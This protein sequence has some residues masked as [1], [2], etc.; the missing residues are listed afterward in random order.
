MVIDRE[1]DTVEH[2]I[3]R[4]IIDY[5]R[6]EDT[7]VINDTRVIPARIV[8]ERVVKMTADGPCETGGSAPVELLLLKQTENDVWEALAGPGKRARVGDVPVSYTHL[9]VYKRQAMTTS[10][11]YP[12]I[13]HASGVTKAS[14]GEAACMPRQN[15]VSP[16]GVS[17][18]TV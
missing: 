9:D 8:G 16:S 6:P 12:G 7:L 3:F 4:D 5:I 10:S 1:K 11:S 15:S 2:K 17:R 14:M 18:V 13:S